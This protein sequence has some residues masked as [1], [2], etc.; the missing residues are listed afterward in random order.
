VVGN[1]QDSYRFHADLKILTGDA[2][3]R[4]APLRIP[5]R[6]LRLTRAVKAS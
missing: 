6:I 4:R 5:A 2:E 1:H 3:V